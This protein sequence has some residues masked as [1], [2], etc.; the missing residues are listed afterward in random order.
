MR[1]TRRALTAL[2]FAMPLVSTAADGPPAAPVRPVTDDYFG[3]QVVD[4]YRWLENLKDPAVRAWMDAQAAHT[5]DVLARIPGRDALRARIHA[6]GNAGVRR[7]AFQRRGQRYFYMVSE[8]GASQ[9]KLAFRDGLD[10]TDR[11]LLDPS[12]L[13]KDPAVHVAIDFYAPSP[14]G[15]WLAYGV[16]RG[17][18]EAS[19]LKVMDVSTGM[20]LPE[21]IE[22]A[23]GSIVTWRPDNRSFF[24][25]KYGKAAAEAAFNART[26]LHVVGQGPDGESDVA[27]FG[28]GVS[29]LDVP[30][31]QVTY[32]TGS[33][34]SPWLVAA[35]NHNFDEGPSTLYVAP[36]AKATGPNTP[37]KKIADVSDEASF[38][39]VKGDTL[40]VLSSKDAP[41]FRI[42]ATSLSKPDLKRARVI[43]PE[44]EG[45][46]TGFDLAE[47]GLY[48]RE[49]NGA[50]TRLV[51]VGFDG[52]DARPVPVPF[53]GNVFAPATDPAEPG[54]L[55]DAQGWVHPSRILAYDP[56]TDRTTDSGLVPPST[57]DA[58]QLEAKEVMVTSYDGTQVPM[59]LVYTK[60]LVLDGSHP[61]LLDGYG[62]Y[63]HVTEAGFRSSSIAWI[64]R[65]GVMA[66]AHIRGDGIFGEAWHRGGMKQTKLNTVFDF[67]ACGQW[68]VDRKY[69]TPARLGAIGG[70][71]GGITIGG[72]LTWR[73]D[74]F[75]ALVV[76]AGVSD[77]LRFETEPDGPPNVVE[78]GS[79]KTKEGFHGLYAMSPYAHVAP[80]TPYPAVLFNTGVNDPRVSPWQ[81]MKMTARVQA[82][83]TSG[84]P[85]LLC[86]DYDAGHGMGSTRTQREQEIADMWSFLLWQMGDPGFQPAPR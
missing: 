3:T 49:R 14:D 74:L 29:K 20:V 11:I 80:G 15:R 23:H 39:A 8:P 12:T 68:L 46:V 86:V 37:W 52:K 71:A 65:G 69:T 72:A 38:V 54:V 25:F 57:I 7:S 9:A 33:P 50:T 84:K 30:E 28:R 18:S 59:S 63:G 73:P 77:M 27:V 76:T 66:Y 16:S 21:S 70:S 31:G 67:I 58:S 6:L 1:I 43:V 32:V 24:Y 17:G 78:F 83:S 55:F 60:G 53:E 61:V 41:R 45:I 75:T 82:A 56:K 48:V 2:L 26:Y 51:K 10:G 85:V 81:M 19:V 62:A 5:S 79:V 4:P 34:R 40:Y 35:A 13:S 36:L 47:D 64:E 42:L 44:G 22:R